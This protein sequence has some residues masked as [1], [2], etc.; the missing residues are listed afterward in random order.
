M[1]AQSKNEIINDFEVY[2]RDCIYNE[3]CVR[4]EFHNRFA[5]F[6]NTENFN[7]FKKLVD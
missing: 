4:S 7:L 3:W 2:F 1:G 6:N 5:K